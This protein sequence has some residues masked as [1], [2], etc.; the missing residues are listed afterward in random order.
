MDLSMEVSESGICL[1]EYFKDVMLKL[2]DMERKNNSL[3]DGS[4][5]NSYIDSI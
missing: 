3:M 5:I 1:I 2:N 4:F